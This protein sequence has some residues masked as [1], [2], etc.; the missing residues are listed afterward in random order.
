MITTGLGSKSSRLSQLTH[1]PLLPGNQVDKMQTFTSPSVP[2]DPISQPYPKLCDRAPNAAPPSSLPHLTWIPQIYPYPPNFVPKSHHAPSN[3]K[4]NPARET[5]GAP[6]IFTSP[7]ASFG[8]C[9]NPCSHL[10]SRTLAVVSF[11]LLTPFPVGHKNFPTSLPS[12]NSSHDPSLQHQWAYPENT[13]A[14]QQIQSC[15]SHR[16]HCS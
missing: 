8:S 7:P 14:G 1:K 15:Q 9:P 11:S 13:A 12:P 6:A 3:P 2:R 4:A 10:Y 5:G 16:Q